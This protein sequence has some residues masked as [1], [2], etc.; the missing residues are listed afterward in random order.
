MQRTNVIELKPSKKQAKILKECMLLSSCVY[1][2]ANY[3]VRHQFFANQKIS[4]VVE[5]QKKMQTTDDYKL[6][7]RSYALPRLHVYSETNLAIFKLIKSKSQKKVGLPKYLKNRKTNTTIPSYLVT[8]A[9]RYSLSKTKATIPLSTLM[10]KKYNVK[11]FKIPYLGVLKHKGKQQRGQ[12]RLKKGKFYL[13]QSVNVQD[14]KPKQTKVV[15]GLDLGIKNL[16]SVSTSTNQEL[17]IG[18][19]RFY[20]QWQYWTNQ[21]TKEQQKLSLIDRMAS[22]KISK[23]FSDRS[24]YQNNLFNNIVSKM[25]RFLIRNNV[26]K[27]IV[28]DL[29]GILENKDN[30]TKLNTMTHNYWS[31]DKLLQKIKNK[32]EEL[33][34]ELQLI[35]EEYTSRT[36]PICFDSSKS[37]CKD[38]IFC[39]QFCGY[40]N[41]RDIVG[42]KNIMFKGMY[43]QSN[44]SVHRYEI[45]PSESL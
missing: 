42:A 9:E 30:G 4:G 35:T 13:H 8:D 33:G 21:I 7:G 29:K 34:I 27:L 41:H 38:R 23:M 25:F 26:S 14:V 36:C 18:S 1:N 6:L 15:A 5:L 28:G 22:N 37:N 32:S 43:G 39:C 12:I 16:L 44:Q 31:F 3:I 20:R 17:I 10:R 24:V 11:K 2:S 45:V 40:V 19:K